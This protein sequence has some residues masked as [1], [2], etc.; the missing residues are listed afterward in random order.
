MSLVPIETGAHVDLERHAEAG[1]GHH[2][3]AHDFLDRVDPFRA[4]LEHELVVHLHDETR[5]ARTGVRAVDR[6]HRALDDVRGGTLHGRVD[7][8]TFGSLREL[9]VA[10]VDV[11]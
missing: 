4:Y 11:R 9:L 3:F 5:V 10:R 8:R 6:D 2:V 7:G 1:R